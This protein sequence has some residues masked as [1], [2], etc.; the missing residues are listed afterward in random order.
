MKN[1]PTLAL[2]VVVVLGLSWSAEAAVPPQLTAG[3]DTPVQ[4]TVDSPRSAREVYLEIGKLSGVKVLF[5]SRFRDSRISVE[6]D[7]ASAA[8]AF[9]VVTQSAGHYWVPV[10]DAAIVVAEDSPQNRREYE[11]LVI[12]TFPLKYAD[13]RDVDRLLRSLV[14]VRRLAT[15]EAL[16]LVAVR[17]TADKMIVIEHLINLIDRPQGQVYFSIDIVSFSG[18]N[19]PPDA[20]SSM[21]ADTYQNLRNEGGFTVLTQ[22]G[23]GIFGEKTGTLSLRGPFF[24]AEAVKGMTLNLTAAPCD[25]EGVKQA[26]TEV[27]LHFEPNGRVRTSAIL[28]LGETWIIPC[29]LFDA[30]LA[31]AVTAQIIESAQFNPAD[32]EPY[33]VGTESRI[34]VPRR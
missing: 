27:D 14:E 19:R 13:I 16:R 5:D 4:F 33:W 1:G 3:V 20:P 34:G 10:E 29:P 22:E 6:I 15:V 30:R 32:L 26:M 31:L 21:P 17:D 24:D 9:D 11:P 25:V 7:A 28:H 2:T 18:S 8:E 12:Q 23:L